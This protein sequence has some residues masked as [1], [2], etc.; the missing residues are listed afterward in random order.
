MTIR[1]AG[2]AEA[3]RPAADRPPP[4]MAMSRTITSGSSDRASARAE[5][6]ST[7]SPTIS[8]SASS[9]S[10][11]MTPARKRGWSSATATR[12]TS[13][14]PLMPRGTPARRAT[15]RAAPCRCRARSGRRTCRRGS[16]ACSRMPAR[17][18]P[19]LSS[20][21]A[22]SNPAPASRTTSSRPG[23][24]LAAFTRGRGAGEL[25]AH[26]VAPAV[27]RGVG[28]RLLEGPEQGDLHWQRRVVRE[29]AGS[30]G[31]RSCRC[32]AGGPRRR[33]KPRSPPTS[34]PAPERAGPL[35]R[36]ACRSWLRAGPPRP[37]R[38][39]SRVGGSPWS[40]RVRSP[41]MRSS[42]S[43]SI[44]PG[45]SWRS[46]LT[47]RIVRSLSVVERS[48]AERTRSLSSA[49]WSSRLV[50][51]STWRVRASS[52]RTMVSLPRLTS[53]RGGRRSRRWPAS[54]A[55]RSSS[56]PRPPAGRSPAARGRTRRP[57]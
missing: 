5:G 41:S 38:A 42:A 34:A 39:P 7:A 55:A 1:V 20:S 33:G 6:A 52:W 53:R 23:Q 43:E 44:W 17:P 15:R 4:G 46:E 35:P 47:R 18:R 26:R 8:M 22:G 49:F 56:V 45:P 54:R 13:P 24:C 32:G 21:E 3:M 29:R 51:S 50:S 37:R 2:Q 31:R 40:A 36:R 27:A 30:R 11:A 16:P 57:R 12:M 10:E 25:H 28:E 48:A 9:R 14:G 19:A